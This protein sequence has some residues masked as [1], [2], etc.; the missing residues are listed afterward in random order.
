MYLHLDTQLRAIP[1][2]TVI[3]SS[4]DRVPVLAFTVNGYRPG[5]VGD[6]LARRGISV[7]TG[8]SGLTELMRTLGVDELG[9]AVQVGLMPHSTKYEVDQLVAGVAALIGFRR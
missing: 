5:D 7:W 9:G 6:Y 3:G 4:T 1:A 2:V 8:D